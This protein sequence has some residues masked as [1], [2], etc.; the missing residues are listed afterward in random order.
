MFLNILEPFL[1]KK[2][3]QNY[4]EVIFSLKEFTK[5]DLRSKFQFSAKVIFSPPG[6]QT[7]TKKFCLLVN[8]EIL[9]GIKNMFCLCGDFSQSFVHAQANSEMFPHEIF[10]PKSKLKQVVLYLKFSEF[11]LDHSWLCVKATVLC[12]NLSTKTLKCIL[13]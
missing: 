12:V 6:G 11:L 5:K 8:S 13:F 2:L 7:V 9:K 1:D 4:L 10:Y 3:I